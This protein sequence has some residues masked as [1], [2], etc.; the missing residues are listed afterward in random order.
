MKNPEDVVCGSPGGRT[1]R[2]KDAA[3]YVWLRAEGRRV[4]AKGQRCRPFSVEGLSGG[5]GFHGREQLLRLLLAAFLVRLSAHAQK[6]L[7][8]VFRKAPA[9]GSPHCL[10]GCWKL[11]LKDR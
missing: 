8:N 6:P 1:S 3:C 10:S 11:F 4:H 2:K 9:H 7:P 5:A